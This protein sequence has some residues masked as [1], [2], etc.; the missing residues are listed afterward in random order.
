MFYSECFVRFDYCFYVGRL[1]RC[2]AYPFPFDLNS[3][4]LILYDYSRSL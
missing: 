3:F 1:D 4:T 2:L